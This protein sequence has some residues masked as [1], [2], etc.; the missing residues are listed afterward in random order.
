MLLV[1]VLDHRDL[2]LARQ[3]DDRQHRQQHVGEPAAVAEPPGAVEG[4]QAL[5]LGH[6]GG[7][8]VEVAEAVVE[9]VG[10]VD[11]DREEGEQLD[12]RLEGDRRHHALVA[13][14]GVEVAGAEQHREGSERQ[15]DVERAVLPPARLALDAEQR[16]VLAH[17]QR[18]AAGDRL[19]LQRDVGHDAHH[20][21]QRDQPA[22]QVALAVA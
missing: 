3:E 18:V 13:L 16:V 9:P 21:D 6:C 19:Q 14:G 11:A 20:R 8:R 7:A 15:R 12:H 17:Q 22:E 2:E 5:Q 1:D 10:D 4:E